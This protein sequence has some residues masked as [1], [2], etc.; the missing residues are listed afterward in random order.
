MVGNEEHSVIIT[1]GSSGIGLCT[2]LLFAKR[3]W[4]VGLIAR[5]A[6]GLASAVA[7]VEAE[8]A[9]VAAEV[10][11][12][13]D[14][15]ALGH[16]AAMIAA[17]LGTPGV[18]INCAG[19]GVYGRFDTVPALEYDRVTAV[20]YAGTVNG[21]R[22]ALA[23]MAARGGGTVVNVCSAIAFHGMP[24]MTSYAGAK[25]AVR[26]FGQAL[27]AELRMAGSDLRVCTVFPPAVNTPFFSHAVSHMGWPARPAPPVYQPEV[28]AAGIYLAARL[29]PPESAITGTAALFSLMC[30]ISPRL[31]AL[32]MTRLGLDGQLTRDAAVAAAQKPTLFAPADQA[33]CVRGAF[34]GA[35]RS[36]S[37][38]VGLT[39]LLAAMRTSK[40]PLAAPMPRRGG[41]LALLRNGQ[42]QWLLKAW[43]RSA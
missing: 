43:S 26:G 22:V 28:I 19:N 35:A 1:G 3:G 36:R 39:S 42:K 40:A 21:T 16:A 15:A 37:F 41:A 30:R 12:V 2:A 38:Q 8:G 4:R 25:A 18:W 7:A 34:G 27:R 10:A 31:I 11:D 32:A 9:T 23:L 6:A 29:A 20:T 13:A 24:L 33:A 5:G 14:S 17:R